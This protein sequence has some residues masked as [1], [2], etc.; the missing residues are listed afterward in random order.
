MFRIYYWLCCT[1]LLLVLT[2][3]PAPQQL[4]AE[5]G[6]THITVAVV[7]PS[8]KITW[9]EVVLKP[10]NTE[11]TSAKLPADA[12]RERR[13]EIAAKSVTKRMSIA[14]VGD[15][16]T[17]AVDLD[18]MPAATYRAMVYGYS[19]SGGVLLFEHDA[20]M[21]LTPSTDL[22]KR[23][24]YPVVLQ[25][26]T[27]LVSL[28]AA[29]PD[30]VYSSSDVRFEAL[31]AGQYTAL[32]VNNGL[33]T[34]VL[35]EIP[36]GTNQTVFVTGK[37]IAGNV[38][39]QGSADVDVGLTQKTLSVNLKSTAVASSVPIVLDL[40][41]APVIDENQN[42]RLRA[43]L[44]TSN[45]ALNAPLNRAQ[46]NWGD[47]TVEEIMLSGSEAILERN[48]VYTQGGAF[49]ATIVAW[50]SNGLFTSDSRAV[51]VFSP[52]NAVNNLGTLR[53]VASDIPL[54]ATRVTA[55][56][57][58]PASLTTGRGAGNVPVK[59]LALRR[60]DNDDWVAD[61][62]L[63]SNA[64]YTVE[65]SALVNNQKL[66]SLQNSYQV[67][68]TGLY[69]VS[70]LAFLSP[71]IPLPAA[72]VPVVPLNTVMREVPFGID[73]QNLA[74]PVKVLGATAG[75][76]EDRKGT[77]KAIGE[78]DRLSLMFASDTADKTV[79]VDFLAEFKTRVAFNARNT[80]IGFVLVNPEVAQRTGALT[81]Q[82]YNFIAR[83]RNLLEM[84]KIIRREG[85]N[86][87]NDKLLD[88]AIEIGK[89]L[90][91]ATVATSG[92]QPLQRAVVKTQA[93]T[94]PTARAQSALPANT[95]KINEG[96]DGPSWLVATNTQVAFPGTF[97]IE[98]NTPLGFKLRVIHKST[99]NQYLED[100][101]VPGLNS[102]TGISSVDNIIHLASPVGQR[103]P[104]PPR[105]SSIGCDPFEVTL[106]SMLDPK[107]GAMTDDFIVNFVNLLSAGIGVYS[108]EA[109]KQFYDQFGNIAKYITKK[110]LSLAF[111]RIIIS[112]LHFWV[113]LKGLIDS[114]KN[115]QDYTAIFGAITNLI[116]NSASAIAALAS[117]VFGKEVNDIAGTIIERVTRQNNLAAEFFNKG[118][119][120]G[121]LIAFAKNGADSALLAW[122]EQ[123]GEYMTTT[124][125]NLSDLVIDK[126]TLKTDLKRGNTVTNTARVTAKQPGCYAKYTAQH[127]DNSGNNIVTDVAP[128]NASFTSQT[129]PYVD[130]I[131]NSKCTYL[132]DAQSEE[133][134]RT[135]FRYTSPTWNEQFGSVTNFLT[136]YQV[137]SKLRINDI[138]LIQPEQIIGKADP[139]TCTFK[140][141]PI[142]WLDVPRDSNPANFSIE[143]EGNLGSWSQT[144]PEYYETGDRTDINLKPGIYGEKVKVTT[145]SG[146]TYEKEYSFIVE[147]PS[148]SSACFGVDATIIN[149]PGIADGLIEYDKVKF[150][151][152][153]GIKT[154]VLDLG[155]I[156]RKPYEPPTCEKKPPE[157]PK[158]NLSTTP[159][160]AIGTVSF[161]PIPTG[162]DS[163]DY[164]IN[165]TNVTQFFEPP[166]TAPQY[167]ILEQFQ[168][169]INDAKST[170]LGFAEYKIGASGSVS[171]NK[172]SLVT[173]YKLHNPQNLV[174]TSG[175]D[176]TLSLEIPFKIAV[177]GKEPDPEPAPINA[178]PPPPCGDPPKVLRSIVPNTNTN[179]S[180]PSSSDLSSIAYNPPT[181]PN[182]SQTS[183]GTNS[184]SSGN[185][186]GDPTVNTPDGLLFTT[187]QLGEFVLAKSTVPSGPELQARQ[188]RL[189]GYA[190]WASFNVAAALKVNGQRFEVRLPNPLSPS[191]PLVLLINGKPVSLAPSEYEM[192][193]VTFRVGADNSLEVWFKE[194]N[195][196]PDPSG[197]TIGV[198]RVRIGKLFENDLARAN[199]DEP[200]VSLD[201]SFA[202]PPV[203]RYRGVLGIPNGKPE[204]DMSLP[205]GTVVTDLD[206][207]M[208]S[209]RVT[210]AED[211]VFTY[212]DNQSPAS[213]NIV[214]QFKQPTAAELAGAGGKPNYYAQI[215]NLLQNTCK[216]DLTKVGAPYITAL[217]L[218]LAAGRTERNLI[219]TG[220]CFDPRVFRIGEQPPAQIGLA[221]MGDVTLS[222]PK[223]IGV[224]GANVSISS[225]QLG[226]LCETQTHFG[227]KY[228]CAKW[229]DAPNVI[230]PVTV[231]YRITGRGAPIEFTRQVTPIK[232]D[233]VV[234]QEKFSTSVK[235][236]LRLS[237]TI[238]S[239]QGSIE[240]NVHMG[241]SG[242][243]DAIFS[244]DND[245]K[246]H[247][248]VPLPDGV[249]SGQLQYRV[250]VYTSMPTDI[251]PVPIWST[252]FSFFFEAPNVGIT[253]FTR[254]LKGQVTQNPVDAIVSIAPKPSSFI[255]TGRVISAVDNAT[256]LYLTK[257][258]LSA[259]DAIQGGICET[260]TD[261]TGKFSCSV[262]PIK[263]TDF[264]MQVTT[265]GYGAPMTSTQN[266]G[267]E[268]AQNGGI[269]LGDLKLT[270]SRVRVA[271][272]VTGAG[273]KL[274]NADVSVTLKSNGGS[275]VAQAK[276]DEEGRYFAEWFLKS[277]FVA[278]ISIIVEAKSDS[279]VA[280]EISNLAT[281][282]VGALNLTTQNVDISAK[283]VV[284]T[285]KVTNALVAGA[286]VAGATVVV[287]RTTPTEIPVC[288]TTTDTD[289]TY[290]CEYS[291][292]TT[293]NFRVSTAVSGRGSAAPVVK[294]VVL[295]TS[296]L[297]TLI[298]Q[299]FVV[300]PTTVRL[301]GTL[302]DAQGLAVL[303]ADVTG[304]TSGIQAKTKTGTGG[305]YTLVFALPDNSRSGSIQINVAFQ[306]LPPSTVQ[307]TTTGLV[308]YLVTA[309]ALS[310]VQRDLVLPVSLDS[311]SIAF[312]GTVINTNST[313]VFPSG[314][315]LVVIGRG[316]S[317][318]LGEL[319]RT[320]M[321]A[322]GEY[323]C[324][325]ERIARRTG[326]EVGYQ[327]FFD[328]KLIVTSIDGEFEIVPG[329]PNT[330]ILSKN[331]TI[332]PAMLRLSGV[333]KDQT[334]RL[335]GNAIVQYSS[336][337]ATQVTSNNQGM[338][339]LEIPLPL[340]GFSGIVLGKVKMQTGVLDA[341]SNLVEQTFT[342]TSGGRVELPSLETQLPLTNIRVSGYVKDPAGTG[343][344][345]ANVTI[346]GV[347]MNTQTIQTD[348]SGLYA[349]TFLL[350]SVSTSLDL[351]I[352]AAAR[353]NQV[354]ENLVV[355]IVASIPNGASKDFV[356]EDRS[357]GTAR[358]IKNLPRASAPVTDSAGN[359]YIV[360]SNT[361][362][363]F[364]STG[365]QLWQVQASEGL[366]NGELILT[367]DGEI[368]AGAEVPVQVDRWFTRYY[369]RIF[370]YSSAG[371]E[372]SKMDLGEGRFNLTLGQA[373][374]I[375]AIAYSRLSAWKS[376]GTP[377]W[378]FA[379][380][381][382]R[383]V[384]AAN[385]TFYSTQFGTVFAITKDGAKQWELQGSYN[386]V[387]G[388]TPNNLILVAASNSIV[389]LKPDSSVFWQIDYNAQGVTVL[390]N[391]NILAFGQTNA[392]IINPLGSIIQTITQWGIV[393]VSS[394]DDGGYV[395]DTQE[396]IIVYK[397]DGVINWTY[398]KTSNSY[399]SRVLSS[400][401]LSYLSSGSELLALNAGGIEE[402]IGI[403]SSSYQ[404][405]SQN[406]SS[407]PITAEPIRSLHF[408]GQVFNTHQ[409][410]IGLGD[411]K[412]EVRD[413]NNSLLCSTLTDATG[414][415]LCGLASA[416]LNEFPVTI[417]AENLLGGTIV[418]SVVA[419][420]SSGQTTV[421]PS[422]ILVPITTLRVFGVVKDGTGNPI[423]NASVQIS[424]DISSSLAA[425]A[426]GIYE[427]F[428]VFPKTQTELS[429]SVRISSEASA[430]SKTTTINLLSEQLNLSEYS[431]IIDSRVPGVQKWRLNRPNTN[432]QVLASSSSG[433]IYALS[434]G[435]NSKLEALD[436]TGTAIWTYRPTGGVTLNGL[437]VAP[438]GTIYLGSSSGVQ[439][440]S[441][442]G[443]F[444][445]V[446]TTSTQTSTPALSADALYM[447]A[448]NK[449]YALNPDLSLR[450]ELQGNFAGQSPVIGSDGTVFTR[451]NNELLAI[452]P[453]GTIRWS[454]EST[455]VL[456]MA[457]ISD[458]RLYITTDTS[459]IALENNGKQLW[460][461]KHSDW[462]NY[463]RYSPIVILPNKNI[464]IGN[465]SRV[466][467][468][469]PDGT[470]LWNV[471][472]GAS[473][474]TLALGNDDVLYA[475]TQAGR[476]FAISLT[477]QSIVW[478]FDIG[479][480]VNDLLVANQTVNVVAQ[481]L[482]SAITASS[483]SAGVSS[484][485]RNQRDNQ[486]S[487]QTTSDNVR[488][489]YVTL[490]GKISNQFESGSIRIDKNI[491]WKDT[492]DVQLCHS[493][494]NSQ[495]NY[496]C[497]TPLES[498]GVSN[499]SY[500][501][502]D[503]G[504]QF[505][506]N[507]IIPANALET[508]SGKVEDIALPL[509]TVKLIG[510][511]RSPSL[512]GI[513]GIRVTTTHEGQSIVA[514]T[515]PLGE[516]TIYLI[517]SALSINL[518]ISASD[519]GNTAYS[520]ETI[521]LTNQALTEHITDFTLDNQSPGMAKWS[522]GTNVNQHPAIG[523]DGTIFT[524][525][526]NDLIAVNPD[527]TFKWRVE[528][529]AQNIFTDF[530]IT[531]DQK[532]IF[533]KYTGYY[534]GSVVAYSLAG[535]FMWE[536]NAPSGN[537]YELGLALSADGS[538]LAIGNGELKSY[539]LD[540]STQFS[541][542]L[543]WASDSRQ[544]NTSTDGTIYIFGGSG[545]QRKLIS[546]KANGDLNWEKTDNSA[547]KLSI[548]TNGK[549]Y[550]L[551]QINN[552]QT[553]LSSWTKD[554]T[555]QWSYDFSSADNLPE[556]IIDTNGSIYVLLDKL[557]IINSDGTLQKAIPFTGHASGTP[558]LTTTGAIIVPLN[559]S[560]VA[561]NH[562]GE[563]LWNYRGLTTI[564]SPA[565]GND[566]TVFVASQTLVAINSNLG[567][568]M[569]GAWSKFASDLNSSRR[570]P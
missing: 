144:D 387:L 270:P 213:F 369:G 206:A 53:V 493:K 420:G 325:A 335:I 568:L 398:Q 426:S 351:K 266:I 316:N 243:G 173:K 233:T 184:Y 256:P 292:A 284:F 211:S 118:V 561:V 41:V 508:T 396:K 38:V 277:D 427:A 523:N 66:L 304:V 488:R 259:P 199:E 187:M 136:C 314:L 55:R 42:L 142:V 471:N 67:Q 518:E 250:T 327:F 555:T 222:A 338:Y 510:T 87:K 8:D 546:L 528:N 113:D 252:N 171:D 157:K 403:W 137:K 126:D 522:I 57:V 569:S 246:Y 529:G 147:P 430:I 17:L 88:L 474:T 159:K 570:Q 82:T 73:R 489:R 384:V 91:N 100:F 204:D 565:I 158:P 333:V 294:D 124:L 308:N 444:L 447:T 381:G 321:N 406:T 476:V 449:L 85:F 189:P 498:S 342:T 452:N 503:N 295:D 460:L 495:G 37:D 348:S 253:D 437:S 109:G 285:G 289:G 273:Q 75:L 282:E 191:A 468:F 423:P 235:R 514:T 129:T 463:N 112:Q 156:P 59:V 234:T 553:R 443:E 492:N 106:F 473:V 221:F 346:S 3:C 22:T 462:W 141:N 534:S 507:A 76:I 121:N 499:I 483:S 366:L 179:S 279:L 362:F 297:Q 60:L 10:I 64:T 79:A 97:R 288:T 160:Y 526:G 317:A 254:D 397:A 363:A 162:T 271:G 301:T 330:T 232:N 352:V 509:T 1:V 324:S 562:L 293:E 377:F 95:V 217:A 14:K 431:P 349:N 516:Y 515:N 6:K 552:T 378:A 165:A 215:S 51:Q 181:P 477:T 123:Y 315:Q 455:S 450:W 487:N 43:N 140:A 89:D 18:N 146:F 69:T 402:A 39:Y 216:A 505:T 469:Q 214:Q 494:S 241:I 152:S 13:V 54:D 203:G 202:T 101:S 190:D 94:T 511:V 432:V 63:P 541:K 276:T 550:T 428:F 120:Y 194:E 178:S 275:V 391:G 227:G 102:V 218:E 413:A 306:A 21:V 15:A 180:A 332:S 481:N 545:D 108:A 485:S 115:P 326:I 128:L 103:I 186:S 107:T 312:S 542:S 504:Q 442:D 525:D 183:T 260:I 117:S 410:A 470:N 104:L 46:I 29:F 291:V 280:Q 172:I 374:S 170:F 177:I 31:I 408:T 176:R 556:P 390:K 448:Y 331:L 564:G 267:F 328:N 339:N 167:S 83:H 480:N 11:G 111:T 197:R 208:E 345:K 434:T 130:V 35:P 74:A 386:K 78:P 24:T 458:G 464:V 302:R 419:G 404:G 557:Y 236:I 262:Q 134:Q 230:S 358:W 563:V 461:S 496:S 45:P 257:V 20:P 459:L 343:I 193:G 365:Q 322:Q 439:A 240:N 50:S 132:N 467:I 524:S 196:P 122:R 248:F 148:D 127:I 272:V 7:N 486:N 355:P 99:G 344:E 416:Q 401:N 307:G 268:A 531:N 320:S 490:S 209:W 472:L 538:V 28:K 47:G 71:A 164:Q 405:N 502:K 98:S 497:T 68:P 491:I 258:L 261:T 166:R 549:L 205:N 372:Q 168:R 539:N 62:K 537:G 19:A 354:T 323:L 454:L 219:K 70:T 153:N 389:A 482:I 368:I 52:E 527:G 49:V 311:D 361:L 340:S 80:A 309:N 424:G 244:T 334:G 551:G 484:W 269:D 350:S 543:D 25:R 478:S 23:V 300:S 475:S 395:L 33:A 337:I 56:V 143:G 530:M 174:V 286:G 224:I 560:L 379:Q 281:L 12:P 26:A 436:Q 161:S 414:N 228:Y 283:N 58:P 92:L 441:T 237:G 513:G 512:V 175:I 457:T 412:I 360:S 2:A 198:S 313:D 77:L 86:P 305:V 278:P 548:G 353:G 329:N 392:V 399:S 394:L 9:L 4:P 200:V 195:L 105:D 388:V 192:Q 382:T 540:G 249:T 383:G 151:S 367:A 440:V 223:D 421:T 220:I 34:G 247:A 535:Q 72:T 155:A 145:S 380:G 400:Q 135:D 182:S 201:I 446:F 207:F 376:D 373:D 93:A 370:V 347:G 239:P 48:H 319:C 422:N 119:F 65:I 465:T 96:F 229:L 133:Q 429:F 5:V 245:G 303:N 558:L 298:L 411:M 517:S 336:P 154:I 566:G 532:L 341:T 521:E 210:K 212:D 456:S 150:A 36:T 169:S 61:T 310:E 251:N 453:N 479:A 40:E 32:E 149:I 264:S 274:K 393:G 299:D 554:G 116:Q 16:N 287:T 125:Q 226:Q 438:N 409:P 506:G 81:R 30:S 445:N 375:I 231:N 242:F 263:K 466:M 290:K 500:S 519:G 255:V 110:E 501:V 385:G 44:L 84:T 533:G 188:G 185:S 238:Y 559:Q 544:I 536:S 364:A 90:V 407:V 435:S 318:N 371:V 163:V 547:Q 265:S 131:F 425:N 114:A 417:K 296:S 520:T 139:E 433:I 138:Q 356:L 415:Y 27:G 567:S 225:P 418:N 359:V 451:G 357:P